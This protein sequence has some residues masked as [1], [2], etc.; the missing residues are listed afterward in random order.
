M[1]KKDNIV[2]SFTY[3]NSFGA[4]LSA[5]NSCKTVEINK[6]VLVNF[7]KITEDV[8]TDI[9]EDHYQVRKGRKALIAL[10]EVMIIRY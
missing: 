5:C 3:L 10:I 8:T 2:Q 4:V 7:K 1:N 6:S 9:L